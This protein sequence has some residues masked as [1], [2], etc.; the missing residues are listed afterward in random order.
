MQMSEATVINYNSLLVVIDNDLSTQPALSRA[1]ELAAKTGA[2]I[3]ALYV[4]YDFSY[5]MTTMLS[6]DEREAMRNAVIK[7]RTQWVQDIIDSH[8]SDIEIEIVVKWESRDFEAIIRT[9]MAHHADIIIKA[10]KK[11]DDLVSVIFTPT[12]WHL[13]RKAPMPV[14]MVKDHAWPPQ[15][16]ILAAVN[17][18]TDDL[19]HARL[20][21]KLTEIARDYGTL[22]TGTVHLVNA[23]PRAPISIAIEIPEFDT[24]AYHRSVHDHHMQEMTAHRKKFKIDPHCCHVEEG[25]PEQV[26]AKKAHELDAEL[27]VIGTVGRVGLSAAFIGNTAEHVI[28]TLHCDVLAVKPDGFES[29]IQLV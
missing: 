9:A 13:M 12:D 20:N 11:A 17:V 3:T 7:D 23:Y 24:E 2:Q 10:S 8:N 5:E 29:P 14:L 1:L 25:M 19:E 22:L 21:D 16:N 6:S 28:D 4:A 18:G 26:V 27:V 15:G